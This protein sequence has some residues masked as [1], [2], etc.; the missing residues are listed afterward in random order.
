MDIKRTVI[1]KEERQ[2]MSLIATQ[3]AS[4]IS[5]NAGEE[6]RIWRDRTS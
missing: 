5:I 2:T 6:G 3:V 1:D 4:D